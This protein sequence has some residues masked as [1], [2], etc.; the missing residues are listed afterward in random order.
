MKNSL[1]RIIGLNCVYRWDVFLNIG[2]YVYL[3]CRI[4]EWTPF[5][6]DVWIRG[7]FWSIDLRKLSRTKNEE[8]HKG[9]KALLRNLSIHLYSWSSTWDIWA[10]HSHSDTKDTLS[11]NKINY[12]SLFSLNISGYHHIFVPYQLQLEINLRIDF[13]Q[14]MRKAWS[15][16]KSTYLS[17]SK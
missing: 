3:S 7:T 11:G 1:L 6:F 8:D 9:R 10:R 17:S 13:R 15:K 5:S 14:R 4:R 12:K 2:M 16:T